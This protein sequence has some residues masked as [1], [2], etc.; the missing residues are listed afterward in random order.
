MQHWHRPP[1]QEATTQA[2]LVAPNPRGRLRFGFHFCFDRPF[3]RGNMKLFFSSSPLLCN[4][5]R[6]KIQARSLPP[7]QELMGTGASLTKLMGNLQRS[8]HM[9]CHRNL[10]ERNHVQQDIAL[11]KTLKKYNTILILKRTIC[12]SSIVILKN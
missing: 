2:C 1:S 11:L 8:P 4:T 7:L 10:A 6:L 5:P 12:D 9:A 3:Q